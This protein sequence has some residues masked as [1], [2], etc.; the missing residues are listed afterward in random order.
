MEFLLSE[1][2]PEELEYRVF[3]SGADRLYKALNSVYESVE[4]IDPHEEGI[5]LVYGE[6]HYI[7]I[8]NGSLTESFEGEEAE[9]VVEHF[10]PED[11]LD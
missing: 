11:L 9:N 3:E 1:A 2:D 8:T 4:R 10:V 7:E 6:T 5:S